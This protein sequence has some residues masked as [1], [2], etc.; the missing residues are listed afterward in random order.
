MYL[1]I[2]FIGCIYFLLM[3]L[4]FIL[5]KYH[6]SKKRRSPF[7]DKFLRSPGES[8][9][10]QI[11]EI[12]DEIITYFVWV[13]T[14]P[15]MLYSTY[16]SMLYFSG[17]KPTLSTI[18]LTCI[19]GVGFI[20]YCFWNLIKAWGQTLI[21]DYSTSLCELRR[22]KS[23]FALRASGFALRATTRQDDGT[24]RLDKKDV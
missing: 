23:A 1:P 12:N 15:I 16:I 13:L 2:I 4:L 24:S 20:I 6:E 3:A 19:L 22:D 5:K 17:L 14:V 8:L 11:M 9:N 10:R 21:L 7:T 18:A